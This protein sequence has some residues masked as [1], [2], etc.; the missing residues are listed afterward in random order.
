MSI[1]SLYFVYICGNIFNNYVEEGDDISLNRIK[2]IRKKKKLTLK[3]VSKKTGISVSSLSAYEKQEG[4]KGYR[5]PK[6][7]KWIQLADFFGVSVPYLQGLTNYQGINIDQNS[8]QEFAEADASK[9]SNG[10]L[11]FT[12]KNWRNFVKSLTS[13]EAL[14]NFKKIY[15]VIND[16]EIPVKKFTF[17]EIT[18][19]IDNLTELNQITEYVAYVYEILTASI[20]NKDAKSIELANKIKNIIDNSNED[21]Y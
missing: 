6:I 3:Q 8:Y 16:L 14:N 9:N 21:E 12:E 18:K 1:I 7:D 5:K 20:V 17:N 4:D 19:N 15:A 13:Q 10:D 11:Y 2:E